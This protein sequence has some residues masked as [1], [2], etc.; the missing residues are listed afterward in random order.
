MAVRSMV[1]LNRIASE[2]HAVPLSAE[3]QRTLAYNAGQWYALLSAAER[4]QR[5][6][7]IMEMGGN[8]PLGNAILAYGSWQYNY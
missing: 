3:V 7:T 4:M 2:G 1:N 8:G 6:S 5:A